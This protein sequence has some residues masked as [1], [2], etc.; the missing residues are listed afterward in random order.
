MAQS[1]PQTVKQ[2]NVTGQNGP[3]SLQLSE[4]PVPQLGDSQVLVKLHGAS[5]NFR[6][7]VIAKGAYPWATIPNV[8][9]GSDGAGTVLAV[10]RHVTRFAAGNKVVTALN[11]KLIGGSFTPPLSAF[12]LGASID[13]TFRTAGA[14]DEQGLVRAPEGLSFVEAATLGC[15][16]VTAWN[17][18]FGLPGRPL[19]AGH[20]L[21]TLGTGGVSVFCVQFAK[22]VGARVI[23]TTSSAE[24]AELLR[25]LGADHVINYRETPEWGAKAKEL[26]GGVG[27]D[28]V[29]EVAGPV[30]MRQSVESIKLDG[31]M[32]VMGAVGSGPEN[33]EMPGLLETWMNLFTARG[34]WTGTRLQMEDM[35]RAIEANLE[36][37]R[38]VVDP[39]VFKLEE[40]K[41][42]YEYLA[43]G[44]HQGKVCIQIP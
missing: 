34:I 7:L 12:G 16:G 23:A 29:V 44:K 26:T 25:R 27:V 21:L 18:L 38:P 4:Q 2:W 35:G 41:E 3:D 6:D 9:P 20:W 17:A 39:K 22:A 42:A 24:K 1:I 30:T 5:L 36:K 33:K 19:A 31:V 43:S 37:L 32:V 8:V 40:L 11:P 28:F 14:F 13:G 15:A 10:G